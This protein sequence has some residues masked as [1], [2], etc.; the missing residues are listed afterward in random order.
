MSDEVYQFLSFDAELPK[1]LFEF[2]DASNPCVFAINSFSKLLGPGLRLGWIATHK[3]HMDR[4]LECGP[5]HS[6]GGFNPFMG[7][8]VAEMIEN[9]FVEKQVE[10]VRKHY[11]STC[12]ALCDAIDKYVCTAVREDEEVTYLKPTGGFFC[13]L[14]LPERYDTQQLLEVAQKCGVSYFVGR[15]SSPD[16]S[17]FKNCV[18]L[19]FA[20][21]ESDV[22]VEGVKRLGKA[23]KEY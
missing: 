20:F 11:K 18:R 7:A 1:S 4:L 14:T 15:H 9:G 22:I 5:L 8:V 3:P 19:C 23:M 21:A 12:T 10:R 13:F 16:K 2:D 17:L 6:G